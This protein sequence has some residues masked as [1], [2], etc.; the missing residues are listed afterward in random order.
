MYFYICCSICHTCNKSKLGS[1]SRALIYRLL[2]YKTY[3]PD[4]LYYKA[5]YFPGITRTQLYDI[6]R[7]CLAITSKH[8]KESQ[9]PWNECRFGKTPVELWNMCIPY[10][11]N[12]W[13]DVNIDDE[14]KKRDNKIHEQLH[15]PLF[16]SRAE[17]LL[18]HDKLKRGSGT[19]KCKFINTFLQPLGFTMRKHQS[20]LWD[21]VKLAIDNGKCK[22]IIQWATGSGKSFAILIIIVLF[23]S[24]CAENG[25]IFRALMIAPSNDILKTITCHFRKLSNY[26]ITVCEGYDGQMSSLHIP[27]DKHVLIITTHQS[28]TNRANWESLP[29]INMIHYDEVHRITGDEFNELLKTYIE[30]WGCKI[31][32]GTSATPFTS[33]S[34]QQLKLKN[35]FGDPLQILHKCNIDEAIKNEW[36]AKPRFCVNVVGHNSRRNVIIRAFVQSVHDNI[37]KKKETKSWNCGKVIAYIPGSTDDVYAAIQH[38]REIIPY[39]IYSAIDEKTGVPDA[40]GFIRAPIDGIPR[41]L[42]ACKR[43]REGADIK[44]TEMTCILMGETIATYIVLQI[45]GRALRNDYKDKE[46]WCCIMRPS[47][48]D[49]SADE[50][51]DYILM[52]IMYFI[53]HD[54]VTIPDRE[55]IRRIVTRFLDSVKINGKC[56]DINDTVSRIQA[57][58]ARKQR[59]PIAAFIAN[60]Q[61]KNI[62]SESQY[63]RYFSEHGYTDEFPVNPQKSYT[64][65]EWNMLVEGKTLYSFDECKDALKR[66]YPSI[67]QRRYTTDEEKNILFCKIDSRIPQDIKKYYGLT[68]MRD[69]I[70]M[71]YNERR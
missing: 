9:D 12:G 38:A 48:N 68:S 6:E 60:V 47:S 33:N 27:T 18:L 11:S 62:F 63:R 42:F 25:I 24:Y 30:K 45:M 51:F 70:P 15:A 65:F 21:I 61:S 50:V 52:D 55:S 44:G 57:M 3:D 66:I 1:T 41:I 36:I 20:E 43:Y 26:G 16:K 7:D 10:F 23:F 54:G 39:E 8:M 32:T 4:V 56:Y 19:V 71:I 17:L 37:I 53:G 34:L 14:L 22:G 13:T 2:E 29:I 28:M 40:S 64:K 69:I 5:A 31:L 46:G 49:V 59:V 67:A 58:F 35:T